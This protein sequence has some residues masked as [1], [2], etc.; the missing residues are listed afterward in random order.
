MHFRRQRILLQE[1]VKGCRKQ[2]DAK[3]EKSV[4]HFSLKALIELAHARDPSFMKRFGEAEPT[5]IERLLQ[6]RH[7]YCRQS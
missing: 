2:L 4:E 7:N 5:F 6:I 1:Q 3:T